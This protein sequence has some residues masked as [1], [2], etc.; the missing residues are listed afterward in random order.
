MSNKIYLH[1]AVCL[2]ALA[3]AGCG[4]MKTRT[5]E[6][7]Y[8]FDA[9]PVPVLQNLG[10]AHSVSARLGTRVSGEVY[11]LAVYGNQDQLGLTMSHNEGDTY[12]PPSPISS[13]ASRVTLYGEAS[14]SLAMSATELYV[15]WEQM[16]SHGTS[17]LLVAPSI[18]WGMGGFGKPVDVVKKDK[19]SFN[20]FSSLAL[21]PNGDVYA[22][23]LDGRDPQ[24]PVPGSL[25]PNGTFSVYIARSVDHG[26]TFGPNVRVAL[27]ACPCCRPAL[28]FGPHGEVYVAWRK[29]FPGDIRDMVVATSHDQGSTF[30]E[31]VRVAVDNW[32]LAGCPDSGPSLVSDGNRLYIAWLSEGGKP[33]IRLSYS[34]D[35]ARSF[36]KPSLASASVLYPN[37]PSLAVADD[38]TILLAFQGRDPKVNNGWGD[39]GAYLVTMS[40]SGMTQPLRLPGNQG[41]ASYPVIVAAG[42]GRIYV[43]WTETTES[44]RRVVLLRGRRVS[45][46]N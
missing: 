2:I 22:V 6:A 13:P 34:E 33:G 21:A 41:S 45:P 31:P 5:D 14:P 17:Q 24:P 4:H 40:R 18:P 20:G 28:A 30:S 26:A 7:D 11:L 25:V 36:T 37:H 46:L 3:I 9:K 29:V 1:T 35:G 12:M 8:A 39:L 42:A 19:P 10:I 27:G 16:D 32:K 43:A 38:G 15:L 44:G 23:W